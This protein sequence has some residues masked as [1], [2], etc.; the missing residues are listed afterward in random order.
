MCK[1]WRWGE[2]GAYFF[3][4]R[5]SYNH[6]AHLDS[7]TAWVFST[8][9]YS[10]YSDTRLQLCYYYC[11]IPLTQTFDKCNSHKLY[12]WALW[13]I[14]FSI[15]L[16]AEYQQRFISN[17]THYHSIYQFIVTSCYTPKLFILISYLKWLHMYRKPTRTIKFSIFS[18]LHETLIVRTRNTSFNKWKCQ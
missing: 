14:P 13:S 4:K 6:L 11:S 18:N 2:N 1:P 10:S 8:L 7:M 5:R 17:A 9:I 12:N 15:R 3:S 16:L